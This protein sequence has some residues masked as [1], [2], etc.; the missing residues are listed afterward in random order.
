MKWPKS[1]D[2]GL[3]W[4]WILSP[5]P[6][7]AWYKH[8]HTLTRMTQY[9]HLYKAS[10]QL[11]WL[12]FSSI[13]TPISFPLFWIPRI[14]LLKHLYGS[15]LLFFLS[16]KKSWEQLSLR[17]LSKANIPNCYSSPHSLL[18]FKCNTFLIYCFIIFKLVLLTY[19]WAYTKCPFC[20]LLYLLPIENMIK[21]TFY[22]LFAPNVSSYSYLIVHC[23]F[24]FPLYISLTGGKSW[25]LCVSHIHPLINSLILLLPYI[26]NMILLIASQWML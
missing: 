6:I 22:I 24:H 26:L 17:T 25:V 14:F 23:D 21:L 1:G 10:V 12:P 2:Q 8:R 13:N 18:I 16:S 3:T 7:P 11:M 4:S 15:F 20:P 9:G 5:H 19:L